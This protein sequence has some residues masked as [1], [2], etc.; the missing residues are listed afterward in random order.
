[1]SEDNHIASR[2]NHAAESYDSQRSADN[3]SKSYLCDRI[4]QGD[5][6]MRG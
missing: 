5:R 3:E 2:F 6:K 1:M 4:K